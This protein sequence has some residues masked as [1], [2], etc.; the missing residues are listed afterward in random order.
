MISLLFVL[1]IAALFAI[2]L[3]SETA[4]GGGGLRLRPAGLLTWFVSGNWP[5][6]V[7]ACLVI[8]GVGALLRYAFANLDVPPELK[9]GGGVLASAACGVGAM[10]LRERPERRA[11]HLALAG[12]AFGI[13]YLTA[14]SA[15]AFFNYVTDVNA[16]ALLALVAVATGVFA[17]TSNTLSVAVL[18]MIG[19]YLAPK[20]AIGT[21]EPLAVYGY[22]VAASLLSLVMVVLRGW[23]PLIHLSFLFTLA[24]GLF[25]GWSARFY[26]PQHFAVMRPL[27][28]AL[29]AVHLAMPLLERK[30]AGMRHFD[31]LYA[32]LLPLIAAALMLKIAPD[33]HLH[34]AIG[35]ATL[36]LIWAVAA[37]LLYLL[38]RDEA[39]G[40][41]LVA[42]L[43]AVAALFCYSR[44]LP[45]LLIGLGASVGVMLAAP[46]LG[47]SRGVQQLACVL[48]LLCA[49]LHVMVSV[50]LPVPAQPFL[51]EVFAHRLV[52][53]ALMIVGGWAGRRDDLSMARVLGLVGYVW[54]ALALLGE[55]L[56]LH[57]DFMP[58][59]VF[60]INLALVG[61]AGAFAARSGRHPFLAGLAV[62]ALA[63]TGW[64]AAASAGREMVLAGLILTPLVLLAV[65]WAGRERPA[66]EAATEEV[67][68]FLPSL[69]IGV[70][71]LALAPWAMAQG[72]WLE[73]DTYFFEATLVALAVG[74]AG[75]AA[76]FCL[77]NS[78]RWNG[79]IQPLHVYATLFAL[80]WVALFHIE[81]GLWPALFDLVA[82]A[83]LIAYVTRHRRE[84]TEAG[85]GVQA[86]VTLAVA[87]V[88]QAMLLRAF[89]PADEVMNATDINKMHLPAVVSLMWAVFGACL[90]WWG[91]QSRS[92]AVWS[93]GA[94]LLVLAAVK[95]VLFDFGGLGQL[96]NI[97]AFIAA[98]LVFL[99]VAWF[100]PI[101]AKPVAPP[102]PEA[103]ENEW[104]DTQVHDTPAQAGTVPGDASALR[105]DAASS[106]VAEAETS[107]R[108][109]APAAPPRPPAGKPRPYR[110][111]A[112]GMGG[113]WL[114]LIGMAVAVALIG[115]GWSQNIKHKR[116]AAQ[117]REQRLQ[118][119]REQQEM[120]MTAPVAEPASPASAPARASI[121]APVGAP[122]PAAVPPAAPPAV[123]MARP[124]A[125]APYSGSTTTRVE[126][127]VDAAGNVEYRQVIERR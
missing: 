78:P 20:F 93:A 106:P 84:A 6:K 49:V 27:L 17:V 28:L 45:W 40:H 121:P 33:L 76:R 29:V 66:A 46:R 43:L 19:A 7:G 39:P 8:I 124:P 2:L 34:G 118:L 75:M 68:D 35:L 9:L 24:G 104:A 59:L 103:A 51:S 37:V 80:L 63:A 26:E 31:R 97:L 101:P 90:A 98:G 1:G 36:A 5:A 109:A 57:I 95:L 81:R 3:S 14:Y 52:A 83:Y 58:Q 69:A 23:R 88:V 79:R 73:I 41:A 55:L 115:V 102:E 56:R 77:A 85:F 99:G 123:S 16:L 53:A 21:P 67:G 64:W 91:A 125:P 65:T 54:G 82:L 18:A 74:A 116:V 4:N 122:A 92:R 50:L 96:G 94:V 61:V 70:L 89:G 72:S 48:A 13:A 105:R 44:D 22:Y 120:R 32:L 87:L 11:I 10:L 127:H 119:Q 71:P 108:K 113:L 42:M 111:E 107:A 126:R 110:Q 100:A 114:L 15:Y 25:F 117:Y 47:W 38:K 112:P 30:H 62:C 12:T 60:A 86:A